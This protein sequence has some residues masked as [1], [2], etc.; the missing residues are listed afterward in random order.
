MTAQLH[1]LD[2][3]VI[4]S[5]LVG[6][7]RHW[8]FEQG[9]IV[10]LYRTANWRATMLLVNAI[11]HLA[12]QSWHHPDLEISY[13]RIL[14]KLTTHDLGGVSERDLELAHRIESLLNWQPNMHGPLEAAPADQALIS[15]DD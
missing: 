4:K 2:D 6:D 5:R 3:A 13:A 10:R 15:S 7:L 12:E 9:H 11:A 14:V 1:L 8:R